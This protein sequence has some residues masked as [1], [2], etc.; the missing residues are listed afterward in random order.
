MLN[1]SNFSLLLITKSKIRGTSEPL[2]LLGLFTYCKRE[3]SNNVFRN[4][5]LDGLLCTAVHKVAFQHCYPLNNKQ[6]H[7]DSGKVLLK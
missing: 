4:F 5:K 6:K 2:P 1:I 3:L 7:V